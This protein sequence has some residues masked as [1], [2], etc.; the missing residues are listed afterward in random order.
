MSNLI[1]GWTQEQWDKATAWANAGDVPK[2]DPTKLEIREDLL[3]VR[4][5][6]LLAGGPMSGPSDLLVFEKGR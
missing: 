2:I 5:K 3:A 1:Y 4:L 6:W